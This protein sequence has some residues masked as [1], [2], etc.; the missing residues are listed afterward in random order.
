VEDEG[1][2]VT[3]ADRHRVFEPFAQG[4]H[5]RARSGSGAGIGLAVVAELVGAHGGRVW[6]GDA[7]GGGAR[8]VFTVPAVASAVSPTPAPVIRTERPLLVEREREAVT[9]GG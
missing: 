4:D 1:P 7:A 5:P 6:I 2:G 3:P 8:V 9:V